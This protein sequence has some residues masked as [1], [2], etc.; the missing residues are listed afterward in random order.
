[1]KLFVVAGHSEDAPGAKAY[2]D[3][4]EHEYTVE[5]QRLLSQ[6]HN[7][8]DMEG[9]VIWD[10][11]ELSL[12]EVINN[13]NAN[14]RSGDYGIDIHFN[15]NDPRARGSEVYV[16]RKTTAKNKKIASQ[17]A[18]G[19]SEIL[20]IPLR[21]YKGNRDYKYSE[22]S[23]LG[24]LAMLEETNIPFIIVEPC[25]LNHLDLPK[26]EKFKKEVWLMTAEVYKNNI[27]T[28]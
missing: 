15:N 27:K 25:F 21:R 10:N 12:L 20:G 16:S 23:H 5:G 7:T 11:G 18:N 22:E 8:M 14:A 1:M 26:Y 19:Y 13:I 6:G 24:Y 17:L 4:Y 28:F 3:K 9:S 2:N